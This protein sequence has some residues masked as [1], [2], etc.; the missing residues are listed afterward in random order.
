[1]RLI[2]NKKTFIIAEVAGAYEGSAKK[3]K[4]LIDIAYKSGADSIKF[5]IFK[6]DNL[7]VCNHPKYHN[8]K[9]R[10]LKEA[11]WSSLVTYAKSKNLFVGADVF[12]IKSVKLS[13]S[14]G[15][16]FY[17]IHSTNLSNPFILSKVAKTNKPIILGVGGS[18]LNEIR[19]SIDILK[20]YKT[21]QIILMLGHQN[22]PTKLEDTN[23]RRI[24]TLKNKFPY[25]VGFADHCKADNKMSM[26]IP[27]LAIAMGAKVI[28]KHFTINRALKGTDYISSLNPD[29][30]K[31]LV[32][33]IRNLEKIFGEGKFMLSDNEKKYRESMKKFIVASKDM[34]INEKITFDKISFKRTTK[35]GILPKDIKKILGKKIKRKIKKDDLITID[36]VK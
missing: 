20:K 24:I 1:M 13:E 11:E 29:E 17:K 21:K 19:E 4:K 10:E 35:P 32:L 14:V 6:T 28:E 26:I 30:L 27:L 12:D 5:Q 33:D 34:N 2:P 3:M 18:T 22:F 8:F 36:T 15:I 25:I 23:L 9:N 31:Q 16:D 7:V